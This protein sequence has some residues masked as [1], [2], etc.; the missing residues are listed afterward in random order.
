[1]EL[2]QILSLMVFGGLGVLFRYFMLSWGEHKFIASFV[3]IMSVNVFGSFAMGIVYALRTA[4]VIAPH[5]GLWMSVGLL[6]G[7]T[8]LSSYSLDV[9][10][11][12][13]EGMHTAAIVYGVGTNTLSLLCCALGIWLTR[14][15]II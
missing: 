6:G 13:K 15:F 7:F 2:K 4:Q 12:W 11:L 14:H 1:M 8:T 9:I 10:M 5:L 3:I